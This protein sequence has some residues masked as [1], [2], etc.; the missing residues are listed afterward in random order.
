MYAK[1]PNQYDVNDKD[2]RKYRARYSAI[3]KRRLRFIPDVHISDYNGL[4]EIPDF[5]PDC[6]FDYTDRELLLF[7]EKILVEDE[8]PR[9]EHPAVLTVNRLKERTKREIF[10]T[11]GIPDPAIY[12]GIYWRTHPNGRTWKDK[13]E[14]K[15]S[16]GSFYR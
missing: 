6:E 12:K 16:N 13:E 7:A 14:R 8:K 15:K 9:D 1:Q 3:K 11:S 4:R 5:D 10:T 2:V